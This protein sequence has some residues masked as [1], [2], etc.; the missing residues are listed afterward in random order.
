VSDEVGEKRPGDGM[1]GCEGQFCVECNGTGRIRTAPSGPVEQ[2]AANLWAQWNA[3]DDERDAARNDAKN[4]W[5]AQA[6][7]ERQRDEALARAERA[8]AD[9]QFEQEMLRSQKEVTATICKERDR[10]AAALR[11]VLA[12][13]ERV[14][15]RTMNADVVAQARAA[16]R[17]EK[18]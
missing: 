7:A 8:E 5:A 10:L 18:P 11:A 16:L 13:V 6:L 3:S 9:A 14:T 1:G 12:E 17:G 4:A 2:R 15:A